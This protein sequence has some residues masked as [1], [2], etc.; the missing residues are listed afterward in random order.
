MEDAGPAPEDQL[1][2]HPRFRRGNRQA[3][4]DTN[5]VTKLIEA[6][7]QPR[8]HRTELCLFA[9]ARRPH[10]GAVAPGERRTTVVSLLLCCSRPAS[11]P[12]SDHSEPS[13]ILTFP[14]KTTMHSWCFFS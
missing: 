11:I 3:A 12:T 8:L 7:G 13:Y 4:G 1:I 14:L 5:T 9:S 2:P 10:D 6:R